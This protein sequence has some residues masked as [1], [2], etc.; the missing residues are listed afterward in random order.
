VNPD[1]SINQL[2]LPWAAVT[3]EPTERVLACEEYEAWATA[4]MKR[5][6]HPEPLPHCRWCQG[7]LLAADAFSDGS[8]HIRLLP[9]R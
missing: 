1:G 6:G 7:V 5:C 9:A 4:R 8:S 3:G 2:T